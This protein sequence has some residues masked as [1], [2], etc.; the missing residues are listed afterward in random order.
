MSDKPKPLIRRCL[1]CKDRI[2][3][4]SYFVGNEWVKPF[5]IHHLVGDVEFTD[6]IC[7]ECLQQM[8]SKLNKERK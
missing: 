5:S 3:G 4:P 8:K 6:G 2:G 7:P 1:W